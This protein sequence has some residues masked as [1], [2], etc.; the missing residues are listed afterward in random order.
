[1]VTF[2][3]RRINRLKK[4]G[5]ARALVRYLAWRNPD[6]AKAAADALVALGGKGV[7]FL[8]ALL[9]HRLTSDKVLLGIPVPDR[10]KDV[11]IR[12]GKPAVEG[13]VSL[14]Y[15]DSFWKMVIGTGI[16]EGIGKE[17][18]AAVDPLIDFMQGDTWQQFRETCA[19]AL[20][21]IRDKEA[22]QDLIY[23]LGNDGYGKVR[24]AAA[25]ALG[26]IGDKRALEPLKKAFDFGYKEAGEALK[27]IQSK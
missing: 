2:G 4:K 23:T 8:T 16:L 22:V 26:A 27:I 13:A 19:A 21:S 11:M 17:A 1:M 15:T 5:K 6:R 14:L 7:P 12:I 9:C 10:I 25:L 3:I 24:K 18:A 20:G